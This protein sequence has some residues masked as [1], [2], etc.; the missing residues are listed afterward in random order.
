MRIEK[1]FRRGLLPLHLI[2][3]LLPASLRAQQAR[4]SVTG[5]VKTTRGGTLSNVSVT[6]K[7]SLTNFSAGTQT[8]S[9]GVFSFSSLQPGN[10]Y[11]FTFSYIGFETQVIGRNVLKPGAVFS[12]SIKMTETSQVLNDVVVVGYGTQRKTA[13][14]AAVSEVKGA[15]LVKSPVPNITA[16]LA[17]RVSGVSARPNGGVPGQDNPDIHVRGIATTGN[18]GA[19]IVI[20]GIIRNNI[21]QIDPNTIESVTILKDAAAVAPYGLGGANGVL[22]ITTKHGK[23]GVANLSLGSYYGFQ[24]PTNPPKM[25]NAKDYMTLKNEGDI[26]SGLTAEYADTLIK[27]YDRLHAQRPDLYPSS[28]A[29][30]ELVNLNAP[31]QN[32][33]IQVQGGSDRIQYYAG[34]NYFGQ[35][36]IT[37]PLHYNRYSYNIKLD[38][39]ATATTKMTLALNGSEEQNQTGPNP[40]GISYIPTRAIYYSNGLW[41]ESGGYSPVADLKS[42][43]YVNSN[44]STLLSSLS[45]EQQLPFIKGL[46][47]KGV[48][49]YDPYDQLGKTWTRPSYYYLYDGSTNPGTYT[50]TLLG[51][52]VTSLSES[53]NKN[54]NFTYQGYL[55]Y[56]RFFGDHEITGLVV[57]EA[58]NSKS[59]NFS[60]SRRGFSVNVDELSLGTSDRL[61]FDNGG[62]SGTGSQIGYVYRLNYAY[63]G[64]YLF[65]ATGRYDGHYYFAPDKRWA[66]FP[67]FSAGWRLSEESFIKNS[68]PSIDNLKI[69]ASWGKSGSLAGQAFQYLSAYNLYG[70]AY[71]FGTGSLVQGSYVPLEANPNITWEQS[72]KSDIGVEGSL[73][74]GHLTF[75][76]DYFYEKRTGMLLPPA[77]TVPIEY[78]LDLA[79]ENA[80][81]MSNKGFELVLGTAHNFRNGLQLGV[82]SNFSY[83][84][85]KLLQVF[86]TDATR[87]N[88]NRSRTGRSY[89]TPFG[90]KALGLFTTK[91]DTNGDGIINAQDGYG[92]TQFGALHPGDVKYA[93]LNKDGKIDGNDE[94]VVGHPVYP[95][96]TYGLTVNSTFKGFD[97]SLFFQGAANSS[98]NIQGYQTV[99]FRI[100][101]TNTS[102]EYYDNR[103]T[104]THQDAKY[105]RA[106][107]S[108]NTNNTTNPLNGDGFGAFS[109]SIW[110]ANTGFLRLKTSVIGY[111]LPTTF[112]QKFK[113]QSLRVYVSGQNIFTV[114]KL[115]FMDPETGY[116]QRE[117]AYPVQKTFIFGLN[118]N[119]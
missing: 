25:L 94:T 60:A 87:K 70:N 52:G 103:W 102:Y 47:I 50:K 101:N 83:A 56:H 11:E 61:N 96:I 45:I 1:I 23:R 92:I 100:N 7:N 71:A 5:I 114:S 116:T 27:N 59:S 35:K 86:E 14:T 41:G 13:T 113:V 54:Q 99:P 53:Y 2:L 9:N 22:L 85:N 21:N 111:T 77:I 17:G 44:I 42:G 108:K 88:P 31:L 58:R 55:N 91:D 32:Y 36:G 12:L 51:D 29:Q 117:E 28:N 16:S 18:P 73:W 3:W 57:A 26:N 76:A 78:G 109:S 4:T 89:N 115:K 39:N 20:D 64:K 81:I 30:R 104:P 90:Y 98:M 67:A 72:N 46:S 63:A 93:D 110:M 40:Q 75:E 106:Y 97:L 49:S 69:R 34:L 37:D 80:G 66:F 107:A 68:L 38:I 6:I 62:G 82:S 74:K 112:T 10:G 24:R 48:F 95:E 65:E 118:V 43:G 84:N 105:P 33:N 19:L 79:Q 119:F 8:D 15:E